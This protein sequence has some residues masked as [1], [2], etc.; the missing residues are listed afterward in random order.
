MSALRAGFGR[1]H[2]PLLIFESEEIKHSG[3]SKKSFKANFVEKQKSKQ[4]T[5]NDRM[6]RPILSLMGLW[7]A[8]RADLVSLWSPLAPPSQPWS[9]LCCF[10]SLIFPH[11]PRPP[12]FYVVFQSRFVSSDI[13][14]CPGRSLWWERPTRCDIINKM[15]SSFLVFFKFYYNVMGV[16]VWGYIEYQVWELFCKR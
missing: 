15:F 12:L 7:C 8:G 9:V 10:K 13:N 16:K 4:K 5:W 11:P 1:F 3:H 6:N 14:V 2:T